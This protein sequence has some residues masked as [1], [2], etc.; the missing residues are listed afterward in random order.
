MSRSA[1]RR[2]ARHQPRLVVDKPIKIGTPAKGT[3]RNFDLRMAGE[4]MRFTKNGVKL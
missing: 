3:K 4:Q 1:I 2:L